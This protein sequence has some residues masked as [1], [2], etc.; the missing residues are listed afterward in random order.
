VKEVRVRGAVEIGGEVRVP[1]DQSISHR[2]LILGALAH[3]ET[4]VR[5][6]SPAADVESTARCLRALGVEISR[7]ED[8]AVVT[9]VGPEGLSPPGG[10][11]HCGNSGTTMRLLA[12]VLAGRPFVAVLVGDESLSRR[13]MRRIIE[14]LSRMGAEIVAR[15]G[16]FPPLRIRGGR[17]RGIRYELPVA[18]AQVKSTVLLAGLQAIGETEVVEPA[19]SR[20]HTERMLSYLGAQVEVDGLKVRIA[21]NELRAHPIE[22]PGDFS[23]AAFLIAACAARPRCALLV[24][25]VGVNPTRT[26]FL[27]VLREMGADV[28]LQNEREVNGE[29]VADLLVRGR[30]LRAAEVGG[31]IVPRLIDELPVLFVLA[32]QAEGTTVVRDARELRVKESDRIAAMAENLRRLGADV[33]ELPDGMEVRGPCRLRGARLSGF[34]DHRVVMA[35]A[36]AGLYASGETAI[37]DAEWVAVSFPGFFRVLEGIRRDG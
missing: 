10:S 4:E 7:V 18:S 28:A 21:P 13:P 35:C 24:R 6:L 22:V 1:G 33:E 29:P 19:P 31:E 16:D 9:G 3:G 27:D 36:V 30:E 14:P 5:G 2:A 17:L 8:R 15:D 34:R 26:G 37:E 25:D 11:L 20:D 32:T 23:S 12:G